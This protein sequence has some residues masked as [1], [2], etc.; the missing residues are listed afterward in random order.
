MV[1]PVF[2]KGKWDDLHAYLLV[3][4]PSAPSKIMQTDM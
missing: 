4:L 1:V 3:S 2:V